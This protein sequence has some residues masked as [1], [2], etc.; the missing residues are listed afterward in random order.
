M[1]ELIRRPRARWGR[2]QRGARCKVPKP[3]YGPGP[4][5]SWGFAV[6]PFCTNNHITPREKKKK[7]VLANAQ[8]PQPKSQ[9]FERGP[10]GKGQALGVYGRTATRQDC[11]GPQKKTLTGES[12]VPSTKFGSPAYYRG[13]GGGGHPTLQ[14]HEVCCLLGWLYLKVRRAG[15]LP[16][17]TGNGTAMVTPSGTKNREVGGGS[18]KGIPLS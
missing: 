5:D 4:A 13:E 11:G 1:V 9:H 6:W 12:L 8:A 14:K 15:S 2:G 3:R 18:N 10:V 7:N 17:Y 16:R